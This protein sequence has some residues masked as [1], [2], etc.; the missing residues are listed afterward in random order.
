MSTCCG[1]DNLTK[2]NIKDAGPASTTDLYSSSKIDATYQKKTAAPA[3]AILTTDASGNIVDSG[4]TKTAIDACCSQTVAAIQDN[5]ISTT[6]LYSSSKIDTTYQKK[7]T[8]PAGAILTT[9][10]SGNVVNSG[11]TSTQL[12]T[13]CGPNNLTQTNIKDTVLST[14]DLY[15]SSKIDA[16][17]QKKITVP[18]GAILTT[19]ASG[20][21]VNSGLTSTQLTACCGPDNLTKA[22]IKDVGPISTTDL[23]SSSKID[24]TYQKKTTAPAGTILTTDA[25]GNIVDSGLTKTQ[26]QTCCTQTVA[27]INDA[28]IATTSL[29]SS[30]KID[31]TYQ[32][33]ITAP[34]GSILTTDASGNVV[35]SGLTSTQLSAC[36]STSNQKIVSPVVAGDIAT[37]NSS[38]QV[39]DSGLKVSDTSAPSSTVLYS[40]AQVDSLYAKKTDIV[41]G[42]GSSLPVVW[43]YVSSCQA[44]FTTSFTKCIFAQLN[45]NREGWYSNGNFRPQRAGLYMINASVGCGGS[46]GSIL[47]IKN[48]EIANNRWSDTYGIYVI[49]A[50]KIVW[51]NGTTD[52]L[53]VYCRYS[54]NQNVTQDT[55]FSYLEA[56]WLSDG[57]NIAVPG[58][59]GSTGGTV[60]PAGNPDGAIIFP[61]PAV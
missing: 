32:K 14:T 9:D 38:G 23:Y 31:T 6:T 58:T 42:G 24:S 45:V 2:A 15:S 19:D 54:N 57:A 37:Y 34:A 13:C 20:N 53:S 50:N 41:S 1:P 33:K 55:P 44:S 60:G 49:T 56:Y 12:S 21:V 25:S 61:G 17:Y 28:A 4:L 47:L 18:A 26:L 27:Q 7:I 48:D 59:S 40:S 39:I 22:N 8:A 29:Y 51:F 3:G 43:L 5:N 16:T 36:C 46:G 30:S 35:N 11:L 52:Y 10:A